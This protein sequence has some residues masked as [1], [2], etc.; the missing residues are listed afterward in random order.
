[1]EKT[2]QLFF[3]GTK[4]YVKAFG[5]NTQTQQQQQQQALLFHSFCSL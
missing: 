5:K 2:T 4:W 1:M 3:E